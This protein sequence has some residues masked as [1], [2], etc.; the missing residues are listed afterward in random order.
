MAKVVIC[1]SCQSKGSIPD[2]SKAAR[3]RCP[4]CGEMFDVKGA[5]GGAS[6][7]AMKKPGSSTGPRPAAAKPRSSTSAYADLEEVEQLP[8]AGNTGSRRSIAAAQSTRGGQAAEGSGRSP[9]LF[10]AGGV[11]GVAVLLLGTLIVVVMRGGGEN[12][13]AKGQPVADVP[14]QEPI[15]PVVSRTLAVADSPEPAASESGA[16]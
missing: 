1:P 14:A 3:I 11:G 5:S 16:R 9:M 10:V 7:A 6:S 15:T 8:P 13:P 4:K 12:A 2:E